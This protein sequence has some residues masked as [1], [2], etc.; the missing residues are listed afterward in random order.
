M[1]KVILLGIGEAT[2]DLIQPWIDKGELSTFRKLFCDGTHGNLQPTIRSIEEVR[3]T[4]GNPSQQIAVCAVDRQS[5][6]R[7]RRGSIT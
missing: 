3:A 7:C 2:F 6:Q 1:N 5:L 4:Y